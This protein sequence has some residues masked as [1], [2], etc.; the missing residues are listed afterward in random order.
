MTYQDLLD[1][2]KTFSEDQLDQDVEIVGECIT[3]HYYEIDLRVDETDG[4]A[5]QLLLT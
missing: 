2:L 3:E 4:Y 1:K 5:L